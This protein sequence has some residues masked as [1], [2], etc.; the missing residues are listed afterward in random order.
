MRCTSAA[1]DNQTLKVVD[2]V[3]KIQTST[4]EKGSTACGCEV[5]KL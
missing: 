5:E 1:V 2:T 3:M 4:E